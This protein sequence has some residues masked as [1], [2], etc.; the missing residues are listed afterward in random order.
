MD[1]VSV[2]TELVSG[3]Y[4]VC[5]LHNVCLSDVGTNLSKIAKGSYSIVL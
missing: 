4:M 1:S 3:L 5:P 2:D